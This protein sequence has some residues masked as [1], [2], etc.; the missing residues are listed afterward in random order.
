M[1]EQEVTYHACLMNDACEMVGQI[2]GGMNFRYVVIVPTDEAVVM[3]A[4]DEEPETDGLPVGAQIFHRLGSAVYTG[5]IDAST[6]YELV[7]EKL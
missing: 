5:P 3:L 1:P 7:G 6:V 2:D 4:G